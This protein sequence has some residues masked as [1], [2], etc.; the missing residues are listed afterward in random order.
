[1]DL[2]CFKPYKG[3]SSNIFSSALDAFPT[4]CFKPYKGVSSNSPRF[5]GTR[6]DIESFKP[7]KGVSSNRFLFTVMATLHVVSNP[8]REYLQIILVLFVCQT[9]KVSNPIREYLQILLVFALFQRKS[10]VSNPIREYL[11]IQ[12]FYKEWLSELFQTL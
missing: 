9:K 5:L 10:Y 4:T 11:Q 6:A 12:P 2:G 8:I 7:Y 1:M 3:V